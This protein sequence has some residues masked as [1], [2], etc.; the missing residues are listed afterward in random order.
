MRKFLYTLFFLSI[1]LESSAIDNGKTYNILLGDKS[2]FVQD[3]GLQSGAP[4]VMWMD[5]RVPAQRWRLEL[6]DDGTYALS[7]LYTKYYLGVNGN[8]AGARAEQR[9]FSSL[10]TRWKIEPYN[11]GYRLVLASNEALCLASASSDNGVQLTLVEKS[12]ADPSLSVFTLNEEMTPVPEAFDADVR[13]AMM[14]GF[15]GQY[16][17]D[18]SIG[19]VLGGGGWWGDAE[20]FETILDAFATT[21]D[22]RYKE[23]FHELYINFLSRNGSDWSGNAFN[24]DITWMTLACLRAYKYFG[25]TDYLDKAKDNFTRMY[26]RAHQPF[27]T[28]I[29][30]QDQDNKL[31]TTSCINCPATIAACY[32]GQLT[33]D[34]S[35]YDKALTI[36]TAQRKLL[37]NANTGEVWDSRS[38]N[39]DGSMG[40]EYNS[41]VSTYNQGT[42]LGAAVA[43]Y[44]YTKDEMYLND[45]IK[46][47]ERSRDHLTN[48]N[49]IISVCQTVNGDLCGF[50]GILMRYVRAYAES[51][52]LEEPMLWLEKNAW[53]A[54][55]NSNSD[56]V[57]W[58][59]WL[60][61]TTEDLRRKE[62]NDIKDV[63]NDAFGSSTAVSVAF[64]AHVNRMFS[65]KATEGLD[66]MYFDDIQFTQL[67]NVLDDG[68]TPN[69]TPSSQTN[70]YICFRNVDFGN[71]GLNEAIVRASTDGSRSFIRLYADSISDVSL[72]GRNRGFL[73][74]GWEDV[75]IQLD[76][77]LTGVHDVYVQ[78]VGRDIKFHNIRFSVGDSGVEEI[79]CTEA[80]S[81]RLQGSE[82]IVECSNDSTLDIF[83]VTGMQEASEN[84][85]AGLSTVILRPGVHICR[86]TSK[87]NVTAIKVIVK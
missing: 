68:V 30:K 9:S 50:K 17:H 83:N 69:T 87:N 19:H 20:M 73:T 76:R 79:S 75:P 80:S 46:I 63:T 16:Y 1:F 84:L 60:S 43:L 61:K 47:Y 78:F 42:M 82:L 13:D 2:V 66:A 23:I 77:T 18:A 40:S 86:L 85:S 58:S 51:Q 54:Y 32:L 64:N 8:R 56:G 28:L 48:S 5:T 25:N 37:F 34:K 10:L 39:S 14:N 31:S 21:G 7:N 49:K 71:G 27:G 62:G 4:L 59:A 70:G 35:W 67:D 38:W 29:W 52:H 6:K 24:D 15:L 12:A 45:A 44:E 36:Y 74:K 26:N 33:N 72:L 53:H 81:M 3:A 65:K 11:D 57:V 22:L 55:Q 41:W